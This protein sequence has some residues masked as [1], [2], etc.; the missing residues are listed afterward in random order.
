MPTYKVTF[1][2][3]GYYTDD[4]IIEVNAANEEEAREKA[5]HISEEGDLN[6]ES[7]YRQSDHEIIHEIEEIK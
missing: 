7:L 4:A 1:H 2:Q 6:F 5:E 3:N